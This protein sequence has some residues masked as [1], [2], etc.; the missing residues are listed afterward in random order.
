[1]ASYKFGLNLDSMRRAFKRMLVIA[2][3]I[4][5]Y[6]GKVFNSILTELV[7]ATI[8]HSYSG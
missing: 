7:V 2:F 1:M 8:E 6:S 4:V 5:Y 3:G